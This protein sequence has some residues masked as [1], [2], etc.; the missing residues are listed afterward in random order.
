M[1]GF[2]SPVDLIVNLLLSPVKF[3]LRYHVFIWCFSTVHLYTHN[4]NSV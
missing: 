2:V 3:V 4:V 1:V